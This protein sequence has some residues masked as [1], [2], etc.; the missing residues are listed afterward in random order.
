MVAEL[1]TGY[2]CTARAVMKPAEIVE[3]QWLQPAQTIVPGIAV[4]IGM[5]TTQYWNPKALGGT[6][7]R[8]AKRPLRCH[9]HDIR[10]VLR[11]AALQQPRRW[12]ANMH[13]LIPRDRQA[14]H[15]Y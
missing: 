8:P 11:P 7:C 5:K 13:P 12:Q 9:I 15:Y 2:Q 4:E 14:G 3:D 6:H 1:N 10:T